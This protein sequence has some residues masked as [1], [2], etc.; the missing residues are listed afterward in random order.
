MFKINSKF[1]L[2]SV[3]SIKV[4]FREFK[5]FLLL[6]F[7][8]WQFI[9]ASF[10]IIINLDESIPNEPIEFLF[11]ICTILIILFLCFWKISFLLGNIRALPKEIIKS[12]LIFRG[13]DLFFFYWILN[14]VRF[15]RAIRLFIS[16]NLILNF[17]NIYLLFLKFL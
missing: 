1:R 10:V 8:F 12:S 14:I 17:S 16:I 7:I 2:K 5:I 13:I 4:K 3:L 6:F 9:F 11:N 15:C